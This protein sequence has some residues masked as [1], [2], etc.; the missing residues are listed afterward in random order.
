VNAALARQT[1]GGPL[2]AACLS[3][4]VGFLALAVIVLARGLLP[5]G[6]ALAAVPAWAWV[7]GLLGAVYVAALAWSVPILGVVTVVAAGVL[8][9]VAAAIAVDAVGA[10][11]VAVHPVSWTRLA[12]VA[13]VFAGLLLSRLG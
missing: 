8:G 7:G 5:S 6:T 12:A 1:G 3:F 13:L 9:Q 4:L 10:F 11:G 2:L